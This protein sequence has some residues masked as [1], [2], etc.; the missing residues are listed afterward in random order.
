[1]ARDLGLNDVVDH[2]TLVGDEI[3]QLRN[4][5]GS[6]RLGFSVLL[7]F[8]LWRGRFP[9][10]RHEVPDD[11]LA[12]LGR[13]VGVGRLSSPPTTCSVAPLSAIEARSAGTPAFA[14]AA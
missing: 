2:F 13:Q 14:S 11:A 4:K 9:R 5:S 12:H 3:D 8:L 6:T 1:M 10:G 7:K